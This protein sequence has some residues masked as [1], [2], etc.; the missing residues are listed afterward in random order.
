MT[1]AE[2]AARPGWNPIDVLFSSKSAANALS[3]FSGPAA[4]FEDALVVAGGLP[5]PYLELEGA[6]RG[7]W[8]EQ[9]RSSY[10][11]RDVPPLVRIDEVGA[12]LRFVALAAARTAQTTNYASLGRGWSLSPSSTPLSLIQPDALKTQANKR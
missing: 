3:R 2:R 9:Y 7:R 5:L 10:V 11:A 6:A 1:W 8:F 12:F 4:P